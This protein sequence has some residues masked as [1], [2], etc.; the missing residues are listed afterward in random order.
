LND[1]GQLWER[2]GQIYQQL[3]AILPHD[4]IR[5]RGGGRII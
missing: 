4:R 1:T 2:N 3:G 5:K